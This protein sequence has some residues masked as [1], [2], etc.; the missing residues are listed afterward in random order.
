M[1]ITSFLLISLYN[2]VFELKLLVLKELNELKNINSEFKSLILLI[3]DSLLTTKFQFCRCLTNTSHT[4]T[5][6][7]PVKNHLQI[8]ERKIIRELILDKL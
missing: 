2:E 8:V 5:R 1:I 4:H 7:Q 6:I 3:L